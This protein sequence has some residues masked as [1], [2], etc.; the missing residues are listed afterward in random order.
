MFICLLA[1][2]EL[3]D[4]FT[5]LFQKKNQQFFSHYLFNL[6]PSEHGCWK[7]HRPDWIHLTG[8]LNRPPVATNTIW[9]I[10]DCLFGNLVR[11]HDPGYPNSY[12]FPPAHTYVF[13]FFFF[14]F[15]PLEICL[16]WISGTPL[17]TLPESWLLVFQKTSAFPWLNVEP[18]Y[19][20]LVL[21]PTLSAIS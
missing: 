16:S 7:S 11:E 4:T 6:S 8:S 21:W 5:S 9:S 20:F 12:W 10:S 13:F 18:S 19:S 14:F 15:F 1:V 17:R 2:F 3:I